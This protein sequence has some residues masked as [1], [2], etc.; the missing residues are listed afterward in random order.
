M[1]KLFFLLVSILFST[2]IFSQ[3]ENRYSFQI[4]SIENIGDAKEFVEATRGLFDVIPTFDDES[5][6]FYFINSIEFKEDEL[7]EKLIQLGYNM[8]NFR[9]D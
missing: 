2:M 3:S 8:T 1:M 9:K 6:Y 7:R 4:E 5:N